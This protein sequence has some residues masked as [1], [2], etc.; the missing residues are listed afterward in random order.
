VSPATC[1]ESAGPR[2]ALV[3][4]HVGVWSGLTQAGGILSLPR[5]EGTLSDFSLALGLTKRVSFSGGLHSGSKV[6]GKSGPCLLLPPPSSEATPAPAVH[7]EY[8]GQDCPSLGRV[9]VERTRGGQQ[10]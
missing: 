2:C 8:G 10:V 6:V 5:G 1:R 7:G 4:S 3:L 9:T